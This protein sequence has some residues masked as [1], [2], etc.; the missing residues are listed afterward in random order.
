MKFKNENGQALIEAL[1]ALAAAVAVIS[2]IAITVIT[3]LQ[4]VEFTKN[5][6]LATQYAGEGLEIVRRI[7]RSNWQNL[8]AYNAA[9]Y[10]LAKGSTILTSMGVNGCGQN[11]SIN[12]VGIYVRQINIELNSPSCQT[13]VKVRSTVSWSDSKCGSSDVFCHQVRL[14]SCLANINTIQAP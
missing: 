12:Q 1:V 7:G 8:Q 13:N 11:I 5:Q 9:N 4:N 10:C 14:D 6:N 2:A 3:S